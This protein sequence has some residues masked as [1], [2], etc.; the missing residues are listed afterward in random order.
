[1]I[2]Y[3]RMFAW[4]ALVVVVALMLA[5]CGTAALQ[6]PT[7]TSST[8]VPPPTQSQMTIPETTEAPGTSTE[9]ETPEATEAPQTGVEME[10]PEPTEPAMQTPEAAEVPSTGGQGEFEVKKTENATLGN[11]LT[12]D[13]QMTLYTFKNDRPGVSTC[14][15]ACAQKWPPVI[16]PQGSKLAAND[17][18]PG[19]LGV[20]QRPDGSSQLTLN[21]M[22]LYRFSGDA[23]PGDANGQGLGN[24]W[25]VVPIND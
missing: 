18:L 11:I 13:N 20:I 4:I 3:N 10:T 8:P 2:R 23:K 6:A 15:G 22:P 5:A 7:S 14:T 21:G 17:D 25:Y 1:M 19:T 24:V 16:V 9:L 12:D